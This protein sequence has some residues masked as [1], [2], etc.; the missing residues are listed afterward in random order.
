M[1]VINA[2]YPR[3]EMKSPTCGGWNLRRSPTDPAADQPNPLVGYNIT[4]TPPSGEPMTITDSFSVMPNKDGTFRKAVTDSWKKFEFTLTG[5]FV[6]SGS[7]V[8]LKNL[9]PLDSSTLKF[10]PANLDCRQSRQKAGH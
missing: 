6:L 8:L 7:A 1:A 4:L 2:E 10:S 5:E 3:Q 9:T